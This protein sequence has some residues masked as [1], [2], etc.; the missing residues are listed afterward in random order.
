MPR[1]NL[2]EVDNYGGDGSY[3]TLSDHGDNAFIKIAAD[4]FDQF[5]IFAVHEVDV[6]GTT[7][8]VN[9][10]RG[11]KDSKDS[12]PLC[13]NG[14]KANV[15]VIIPLVENG[16]LKL[17]VR[18]KRI[19]NSFESL[20]RR[21]N[22]LSAYTMEVERLGK[23][24]DTGTT[25]NFYA[26]E[27]DP[28]VN[29]VEDMIQKELG[30]DGLELYNNIFSRVVKDWT[31]DDMVKYLETGEDPKDDSMNSV[32]RRRNSNLS[33]NV[34]SN[35]PNRRSALNKS[36]KVN[37][38]NIERRRAV[39][40]MNSNRNSEVE[41]VNNSDK[42][43]SRGRPKKDSTTPTNRVNSKDLNEGED[44]IDEIEEDESY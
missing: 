16:V 44:N 13:N 23:K 36:N 38:P 11:P 3:F 4:D 42:N 41:E 20:F 14:H 2:D 22:P 40:D 5:G 8:T 32:P 30:D 35:V 17:W 15:K 27:D 28:D 9:C 33:N 43:P 10:L 24:G 18:G 12:C 6:N 34:S 7:M 29:S 25:Y 19:L 31:Y 21:Y 39:D 26:N 37:T 1:I